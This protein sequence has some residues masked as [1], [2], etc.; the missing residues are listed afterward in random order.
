MQDFLSKR[1]AAWRQGGVTL[2]AATGK[3]RF[4]ATPVAR[5]PARLS[6]AQLRIDST[7]ATFQAAWASGCNTVITA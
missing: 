1:I 5:Q 4:G 2:T 3:A 7:P 6:S